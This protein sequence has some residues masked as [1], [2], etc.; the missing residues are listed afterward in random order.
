MLFWRNWS[1]R[2]RD[3]K[4]ATKLAQIAVSPIQRREHEEKWTRFH[5][6]PDLC[7]LCH[8]CCQEKS[9][10]SVGSPLPTQLQSVR[11]SVGSLLPTQ[12]EWVNHGGCWGTTDDFTTS[13]LHFPLF[14]T[15]LWDLA[16]SRPVHS[17]TMSSHLFFC[18]PCRLL[19][20][21]VPCKMI[22]A[23]PDE[24]ET[25]PYHFS[26]CLLWH[27]LLFLVTWS[28]YEICSVVSCISTS[29]PWLCS[30]LQ[31][32]CESPWLTSILAYVKE[33]K[34]KGNC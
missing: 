11:E 28:L 5:L 20:S 15:A 8:S 9:Q 1:A 4:K 18:L 27:R 25:C 21:T 23:I 13:F 2:I 10:I 16:N 12:F 14:S 6:L 34:I 17:L 3:G 32:C 7:P 31:L 30:S 26:L 22:L 24:Q 19:P 33:K 29:F